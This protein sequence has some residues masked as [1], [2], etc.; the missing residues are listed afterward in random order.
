M[1]SKLHLI[2]AFVVFLLFLGGVGMF[3]VSR[4]QTQLSELQ[5]TTQILRSANEEFRSANQRLINTNRTT[6]NTLQSLQQQNQDLRATYTEL[7]DRFEQIQLDAD[8]VSERFEDSDLEAIA[9][10]RPELL[11]RIINNAT[12]NSIRCFE[13]LSGARLTEDEQNATTPRDFNSECPELFI[14]R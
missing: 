13:L 7:L 2:A 12:E 11:T 5:E 9:I 10:A 6:T 1:F 14:T 4:T 3:Y 8:A